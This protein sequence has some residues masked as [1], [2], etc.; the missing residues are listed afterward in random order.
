M[1]K[2]VCLFLLSFLVFLSGVSAQENSSEFTIKSIEN[3]RNIWV[4]S[5]FA[6]L[7]ENQRLGQLFNVAAYSN[8]TEK[9]YEALEKLISKYNIGG[10]TFFQG[11]PV[12]QAILTNRY[13]AAAPTPLL[14][15]MDAETGVGMRL[16]SVFT[17]P[18]QLTLG[19]IKDDAIVYAMG[20]EIAYQ[21]K[22]M[23]MHI[24]FAP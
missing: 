16:D 17:F 8:Q 1:L 12:R 15:A 13:Q 5:V 20:K 14:I 22:R 7:N 11:G 24:N 23:G 4:D 18:K 3:R 21:F 2:K 9:E 10:L 6:S 19:A